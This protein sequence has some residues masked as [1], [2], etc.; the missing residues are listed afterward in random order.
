V[1]DGAVLRE[2]VSASKFPDKQGKNREFLRFQHG[3]DRH[4]DEKTK[5]C[6]GFFGKFPTQWNRELLLGNRELF[7]RIREFTGQIRE[8]E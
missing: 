2:P 5:R 1:A 8:M 7:L 3:S 6:L 4:S